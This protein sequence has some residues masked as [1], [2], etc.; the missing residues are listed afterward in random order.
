MWLHTGNKRCKRYSKS[1]GNRPFRCC[2]TNLCC[3][4]CC[5]GSWWWCYCKNIL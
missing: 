5:G 4:T 2:I 1:G 3:R